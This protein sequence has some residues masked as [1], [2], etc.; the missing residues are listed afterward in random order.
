MKV[1]DFD[2]KLPNELIAQNPI[3]KR[4][5]S[6]LL[7]MDRFTGEVKHDVFYNIIDYLSNEDVLVI[8]NTK[9][10]PSRII[11]EKVDTK[12]KI[13]VLLLKNKGEFYECLVKPFRR[14]KQGTVLDFEGLFTG[15]VLEKKEE[16]I[17]L[18][19]FNYEGIFYDLL[20]KVGLMPLPPYIHE[21]LKDNSRY[22]TIYAKN[23]GSAAAPTAGFHFTEE[24]LEKIKAKGIEILEVSLNIGLDTFRDVKV[25]ELEDHKMHSETYAISKEVADRLNDVKKKGKR[26]IAVGTTTTRTLEANFTKY[27]QFKEA[28]EDTNIFIYPGYQ[29]KAIDSMITNFHLPKST[30]IM[31]VSAFSKREYILSAYEEAIKNKYRFF[32]FGDAMFIK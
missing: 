30:L 2:Y 29:Y 6:K 23:L 9:V 5:Y 20:N 3:D 7:I 22:Q 21:K 27:G 13:E 31:M 16:G 17:C 12:A 32:S 10:V 18:L 24:L 11:G 26:I 19:K 4:E 28:C 15:E 25:E 14:V 1:S 8:N